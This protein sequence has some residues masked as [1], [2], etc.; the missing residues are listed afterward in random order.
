[1]RF[2]TRPSTDDVANDFLLMDHDQP[3]FFEKTSTLILKYINNEVTEEMQES[4]I[5]TF[6]CDCADTDLAVLVYYYATK[7]RSA[8]CRLLALVE[9][10]EHDADGL[11]AAIQDLFDTRIPDW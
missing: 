8:K 4:P 10:K 1:M 9:P 5:F 6:S 2:I 11:F 7:S 3:N